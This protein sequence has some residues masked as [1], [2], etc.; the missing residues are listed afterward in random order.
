MKKELLMASALVA[1]FGLAGVAEAGA[2]ASTS[3]HVRAGVE[4][5]DTDAG[6][7]E[8]VAAKQLG[9][10]T[11]SLSQT[12]DSGI[13]VAT[14]FDLT[15]ESDAVTDTSGITLTFNSGAKLDLI[16]AGNAMTSQLASVPGASG[17]QGIGNSTGN[18]APTALSYGDTSDA[19]GFELHSAADA[20]GVDGLKLGVSASFNDDAASNT[21]SSSTSTTTQAF[22]IGASYVADAGDTTVTIGGGVVQAEGTNTTAAKDQSSVGAVSLSAVTGDLTIGVGYASGDYIDT[23]GATARSYDVTGASF[24]SAGAK[25]VSGDMTFAIGTSSGEGTD[26]TMGA[27]SS[28]SADNRS[29]TA[30]S[31]DYAVADGVTATIGFSS[32]TT[33]DNGTKTNSNSGT[34]WYVGATVSF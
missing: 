29:K 8:T 11:V 28:G 19:V 7:D 21:S 2:A 34:A 17:E 9:K 12:T 31:V 14:G 32:E 26:G 30:A 4:S 25:Y 10:F 1:S 33:D 27:A 18:A 3:G 20:F 23:Q 13:K 5:Q 22:S 16:E 24:T 15:N 6:G